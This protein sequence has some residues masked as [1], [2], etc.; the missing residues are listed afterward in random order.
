[1]RL[2]TDRLIMREWTQDDI[3]PFAAI[4]AEPA[5]NRYLPAMNE[6][7]SAAWIARASA[8]FAAHGWGFWAL[9]E[10]DTGCLIGL[11]GLNTVAWE[12]H[13]TPAIEIGWRLA[14]RCHGQGYAHEAALRAI[15]FAFSGLETDRIVSFTVPANTA[16]WGLMKRLGMTRLED[17]DHPNLPDGHALKRHVLY[18]LKRAS[19]QK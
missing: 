17:F 12:A 5:V 16:S 15:D 14:T 8:H 9:E 7:Q 2:N 4:N 18:E 13:F 11:C 19:H 1:M 10:R 3:K 6:A